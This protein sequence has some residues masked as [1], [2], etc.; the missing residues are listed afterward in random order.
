[1]RHL[2]HEGYC[3]LVRQS[4]DATG[5]LREGI[6]RIE[7]LDVVGDPD[8][9]LLAVGDRGGRIAAI[10]TELRRRG[11]ELGTQGN[12]ERGEQPTFHLTVTA[13]H[14]AV[15]G[16][17]LSDLAEAVKAVSGR[18]ARGEA[19]LPDGAERGTYN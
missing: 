3:D 19:V 2:G 4:L 5:L 6:S 8:I 9:N 16:E 11:W 17:F 14:L 1:M 10:A 12:P 7:G 18:V 13:S 15:A